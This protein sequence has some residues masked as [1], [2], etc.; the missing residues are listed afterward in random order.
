MVKT[1]SKKLEC[2]PNN[3][4]ILGVNSL[5][6]HFPKDMPWTTGQLWVEMHIH[7]SLGIYNLLT[8]RRN[9]QYGVFHCSLKQTDCSWQMSVVTSPES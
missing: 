5:D 8:S 1:G 6:Q 3:K 9:S 7:L 4:S 2:G